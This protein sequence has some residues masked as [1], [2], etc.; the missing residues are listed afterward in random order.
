LWA[1]EAKPAAATAS[2]ETLLTESFD[3]AAT[4]RRLEGMHELD[5]ALDAAIEEGLGMPEPD[6]SSTTRGGRQSGTVRGT[7]PGTAYGDARERSPSHPASLTFA[8]LV[9]DYL[10]DGRYRI[11]RKLGAG[12]I[13]AVFL[14]HDLSLDETVALKVLK[15]M[16]DAADDVLGRFKTEIKITRRIVHPNVVRTYDFGECGSLPYVAMEYV[17][18]RDLKRALREVGRFSLTEGIR[19]VRAVCGALD[20][21]HRLDVVHR[22][23]KPQNIL[24]DAQGEV[25]LIDFGIAK[26]KD[27]VTATLTEMFIGTPE[28]I[29]PEMALGNPVDRRTDVYSVGVVMYEVFCGTT[30]F[31]GGTLVS[32]LQR[33]VGESP[34]PP[35]E[36]A[37]DLPVALEAAIL[38]SLAKDPGERQQEIVDLDA[39]LARVGA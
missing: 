16:A 22:D 38:R 11:V 12:G 20:A 23:I 4:T 19:I 18:G 34:K 2:Y 36:L 15:P 1:V 9:E 27:A 32:L 26:I 33:H 14:A 31:R 5:S 6:R 3:Y 39:E 29:S 25:K 28:Y 8:D 35:R 13:G 17:D 30:P 10:F 37:P 24:L 21:A 7:K